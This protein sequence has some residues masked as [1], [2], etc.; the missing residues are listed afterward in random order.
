MRTSLASARDKK[1][2]FHPRTGGNRY[3]VIKEQSATADAAD[4]VAEQDNKATTAAVAAET[5]SKSD[6]NA[7]PAAASS[8]EKKTAKIK[9][10]T[11]AKSGGFNTD[12]LLARALQTTVQQQQHQNASKI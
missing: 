4:S 5:F 6:A 8:A 9:A 12:F 11:T 3:K 2:D 7:G 1:T 10:A